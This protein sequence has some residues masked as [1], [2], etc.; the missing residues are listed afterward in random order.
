M[1]FAFECPSGKEVTNQNGP[2][3]YREGVPKP[4]YSDIHDNP[5][6]YWPSLLCLGK[7]LLP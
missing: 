4:T 2:G 5:D 1:E 6:A 7:T 3:I